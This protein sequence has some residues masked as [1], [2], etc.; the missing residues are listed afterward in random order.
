MQLLPVLNE[1]DTQSLDALNRRLWAWV[2]GEYHQSPHRGL[3]GE[4]PLDRW[5]KRADEVKYLDVRDDLDELCLTEAKRKVQ[6]DRTV[7]LNGLVYE[8]DASLVG[9]TVCLRFEP[10]TQAKGVQCLARGQEGPRRES[11]RRL[12]QRLRQ[13]EPGHQRAVTFDD[14]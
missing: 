12:R 11:G 1:A 6:K 4:T 13:T 10:A 7:S 14:A 2:E 3:D 5:A 9:A 8:V